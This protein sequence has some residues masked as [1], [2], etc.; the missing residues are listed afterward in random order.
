MD[1]GAAMFNDANTTK[2]ALDGAALGAAGLTAPRVGRAA[3]VAP[4]ALP[5]PQIVPKKLITTVVTTSST[6]MVAM[7]APYCRNIGMGV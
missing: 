4:A 3:E 7:T 5:E 6:A 1:D 2:T